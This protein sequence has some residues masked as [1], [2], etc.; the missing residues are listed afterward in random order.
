MTSLERA[1][2][3]LAASLTVA[4]AGACGTPRRSG[5]APPRP[6][7]AESGGPADDT[8][9]RSAAV[10]DPLADGTLTLAEALFVAA[11]RNPEI[12]LARAEVLVADARVAIA[13]TWPHDP[14]VR[15]EGATDAFF[16]DE[17]EGDRSVGVAQ[18]FETG[19]G[20]GKRTEAARASRRAAEEDA[21]A[22]FWR[23]RAAVTGAFYDLLAAEEDVR[24]ARRRRDISGELASIAEIRL[25]A[26]D[27]S[28]IDAN[29]VRAASHQAEGA[30]A[31]SERARASASLRLSRLLGLPPRSDIVAEGS[32]PALDA[33]TAGAGDVAAL[34]ALA[35]ESRREIAAAKAER[36]AALARADAASASLWPD[37]TL[38]VFYARE[39]SVF[40]VEPDSFTDR[41]DVL[42]L[43]VE[44][45]LPLFGRGKGE[46]QEALAEAARAA[47]ELDVLALD[48][49]A[50]VREATLRAATARDLVELYE[51]K[52]NAL[53]EE[54]RSLV[55]EAFRLGQ[56][57]AIEVLRAREEEAR[58]EEGYLAARHAAASAAVALERALG[59]PAPGALGTPEGGK[60]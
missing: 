43:G 14:S 16:A 18:T 24:L 55:G 5:A 26:A 49:S 45:P 25:R 41:D 21:A 27:V 54:N 48:V 53:A 40:D 39:T 6:E 44:I 31:T 19:G 34:E 47:L 9:E 3:V 22:A 13:S 11:S 4:V 10:A 42:G 23:A 33:V 2:V 32:L 38:D 1:L 28:L 57:G 46:R 17:G 59:A 15:F 35:L 7:P 58:I 56:V 60:R 50:E 8:G 36:D 52:L 37:V 30:L 20:R 12:L 51:G 29:L